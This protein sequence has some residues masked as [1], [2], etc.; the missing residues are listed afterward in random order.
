MQDDDD[1]DTDEEPL[2][3]FWSD[4]PSP[5]QPRVAFRALGHLKNHHIPALGLTGVAFDALERLTTYY[6]NASVSAGF[7]FAA[8]WMVA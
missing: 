3:K 7:D 8:T 4:Q 1:E 5:A 2:P 6:R